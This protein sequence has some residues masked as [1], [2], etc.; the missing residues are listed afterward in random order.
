[1][2]T[3]VLAI[4]VTILTSACA[5][6][7]RAPQLWSDHKAL[8]VPVAVCAERAYNILTG[9]GYSSVVRNGNYS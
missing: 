5:T 6:S 1:M 9:L 2:K 8:P 7:N 3:I 4:V